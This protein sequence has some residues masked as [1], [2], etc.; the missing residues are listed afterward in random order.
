MSP[1]L[2]C[3]FDMQHSACDTSIRDYM[4]VQIA[5]HTVYYVIIFKVKQMN[6]W[7]VFKT[8]IPTATSK[9]D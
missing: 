9:S 8:N 4:F 7:G 1:D 3:V 2:I 6:I 5:M